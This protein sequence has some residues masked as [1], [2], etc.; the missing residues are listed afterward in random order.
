MLAL[1]TVRACKYLCHPPP[2][3]SSYL[4]SLEPDSTSV[5]EMHRTRSATP[6]RGFALTEGGGGGDGVRGGEWR[7]GE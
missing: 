7:E 6:T 5:S 1:A 2:P 4:L 3:T